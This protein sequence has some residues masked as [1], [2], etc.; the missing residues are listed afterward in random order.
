[1]GRELGLKRDF[2]RIVKDI[3]SSQA[4]RGR[5]GIFTNARQ[6]EAFL[7]REFGVEVSQGDM[8]LEVIVKVD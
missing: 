5:K 2:Q 8:H 7:A 3:S 4:E 1:M 6:Q